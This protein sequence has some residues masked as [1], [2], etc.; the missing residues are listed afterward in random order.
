MAQKKTIDDQSVLEKALSVISR[1]GPDSFTLADVGKA[2]GLAPA[3]LLQ[4]FGS[5]QQLLTL[6]AKQANIKLKDDLEKLR[7]KKLPWDQE[8][9][10]LLSA[11]PKGF[12]S[13]QNIANSLGVLKLDMV[14]PELHPI[15]RRLFKTLRQRIK[16]LLLEGQA[17]RQLDA[18]LDVEVITWEL[19][20]LRHGLVIQWTLSGK[21]TLQKWMQKGFQN[22]FKRINK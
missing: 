20:A 7:R 10:H 17:Y 3:T 19:D 14:D 1:H 5:K 4:R 8:L 22:Y 12:G 18:S 21:G 15:A 16:E 9:I 13:R 6:T 11:M 2:V